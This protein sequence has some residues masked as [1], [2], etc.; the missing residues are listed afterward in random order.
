MRQ[1]H[2]DKIYKGQQPMGATSGIQVGVET[3]SL[4]ATKWETKGMW[5]SSPG[6][7]KWDTSGRG[8]IPL[9][10]TSGIQRVVHKSGTNTYQRGVLGYRNS[11]E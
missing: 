2:E 8:T 11:L 4:G 3:T 1:R 6:A 10:T 5:D 7:T 9:E